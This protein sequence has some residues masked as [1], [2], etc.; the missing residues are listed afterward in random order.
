MSRLIAG[1][2]VITAGLLI[3]SARV[4]QAPNDLGVFWDNFMLNLGTEFAGMAM[5]I[6]FVDEL[7]KWREKRDRRKLAAPGARQLIDQL[8][9]LRKGYD[10]NVK[11]TNVAADAIQR[12]SD[13]VNQ[14]TSAAEAP[15]LLFSN[16]PFA[17]DLTS[18]VTQAKAHLL[19]LRNASHAV[20]N[21]AAN[22]QSLLDQVRNESGK[23]LEQSDSVIK[24]LSATYKLSSPGEHG[25]G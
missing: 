18:F 24:R 6:V 20:E 23:L 2:L 12:Y 10:E 4:H 21:E 14:T 11:P 16:E 25:N 5:T 13:V 1:V 15:A 8:R 17:A 9:A 7:L 3:I 22:S 19:L